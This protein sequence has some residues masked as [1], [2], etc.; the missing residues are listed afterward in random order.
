MTGDFQSP[1]LVR[2]VLFGTASLFLGIGCFGILNP[3]G[4]M[5]PVGVSATSV[6]GLNELRANYGSL[7]IAL[8]V[9]VLY[10][11]RVPDWHHFGL[12]LGATYMGGLLAG[13]VVSGFIDG[14]PDPFM[15]LVGVMEVVG[16][17]FNLAAWFLL[18]RARREAR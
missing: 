1:L 5:N 7:Q 15:L 3:E 12:W 17:A 11:A 14:L 6:S 8:G 13:R 4:L 2:L 9:L 10:A 18:R 16:V